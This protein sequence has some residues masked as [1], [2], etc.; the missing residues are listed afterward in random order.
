MRTPEFELATL[1]EA[2]EPLARLRAAL[3]DSAHVEA[4][5]VP[6][7]LAVVRRQPGLAL[8][9]LSAEAEAAVTDTERQLRALARDGWV[10]AAAG[11][12]GVMRWW[13]VEAGP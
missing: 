9:E 7:L 10:R 6:S 12:D 3:A 8:H 2:A 5:P 13:A 11:E 4:Q 1:D